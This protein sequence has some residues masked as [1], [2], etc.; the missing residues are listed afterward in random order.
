MLGAG[1]FSNLVQDARYGIRILLKNPVLVLVATLSL[2]FG[3][4]T[5][6]TVFNLLRSVLLKQVTAVEPERLV[7]IKVGKGSLISYPNYRELQAADIFEGLAAY[8]NNLYSS[9]NWRSGDDTKSIYCQIVSSNFFEV[10]GVQGTLGRTFTSDEARPEA[11]PNLVVLSHGFWTT[12]LGSDSQV[13]GKTLMLNDRPYTVIG[14]LAKGHRAVS[15]VGVNPDMYVPI[16]DQILPKTQE[17]EFPAIEMIGRLRPGMT[18]DQAR[19]ALTAAVRNL[20]AVYPDVNKDLSQS[21]ELRA[22]SGIEWIKRANEESIGLPVLEVFGVL[23]TVAGLVLLI[24]CANIANLLLARGVNRRQEIG[25]RIALGARRGR[26]IQQLLI[27]TLLLSTIAT[28]LGLLLNYWFVKLLSQ[29]ELPLPIPIQMRLE[30]DWSVLA[31]SLLLIVITTILCGLVPALQSTRVNL[32]PALKNEQPNYVHRRFTLRNLLVVVQVAVSIVL[33]VGAS[34]FIRNLLRVSSINPGFDVEHTISADVSLPSDRYAAEE[35]MLYIG[36]ALDALNTTPGVEAASCANFSPL[37]LND[38]GMKIRRDGAPE[39]EAFRINIQ[40]VSDGYFKTMNIP[41]L[42]GRE[43]ER[44]Y[45]PVT[46]GSPLAVIINQ[47]FS[48]RYFKGE[49]A[50]GKR[51]LAGTRPLEIIGVVRDSKYRSLGEQPQ[52]LIYQS[53]QQVGGLLGSNSFS[54][55]VRTT[56]APYPMLAPVKK[57]LNEL[58]PAVALDVGT[59]EERMVPIFAPIKMGAALLG[60]LAAVGL[61]LAMLGLYGVMVYTID[62]RSHE[63]GIRMALGSTQG[64]IL[65]MVAMDAL[66][67]IVIGLVIGVALSLLTT[68]L[69]S[70]LITADISTSDPLSFGLAALLFSIVGIGTSIW[71]ARKAT[72]IDPII[73]LRHQ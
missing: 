16:S 39:A 44:S 37:S 31:Y 42:G 7:N 10:L 5:N 72:L 73:A 57:R 58:E 36:K 33:M 41:L 21:V 1:F 52:P 65:R 27:E 6:T 12:S 49:D 56:A 66:V 51:L 67:L 47:T 43:F 50:V 38:W 14:V 17:R 40:L 24:A 62:K 54:I 22:M 45:G 35:R 46:K 63:I 70:S 4:G 13:L 11:N 60:G 48:E 3:I 32:I 29:V 34:L 53:Y 71:V 61:I 8:T 19:A 59:M 23:L 64:R 15:G 9:V 30:T 69:L 55:L 2:G 25:I 28:A 26:L 68:R 20:E 18:P